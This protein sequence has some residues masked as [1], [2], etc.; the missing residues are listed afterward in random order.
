MT[1]PD[2][3]LHQ[4]TLYVLRIK[5]SGPLSCVQQLAAVALSVFRP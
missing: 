2:A 5:G 1:A 4:A 3:D